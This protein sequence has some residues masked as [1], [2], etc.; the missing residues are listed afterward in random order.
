M[1]VNFRR[2]GMDRNE[3]GE[4]AGTVTETKGFFRK[5]RT[6]F[7]ILWVEERN[8]FDVVPVLLCWRKKTNVGEH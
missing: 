1:I 8:S 4:V 3:E 7:F 2:V 5:K 6:T